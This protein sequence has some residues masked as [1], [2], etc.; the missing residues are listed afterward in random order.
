VV[1]YRLPEPLERG[2]ASSVKREQQCITRWYITCSMLK[3]QQEKFAFFFINWTK[4]IS[5]IY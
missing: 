2:G 3:I 1:G 4:L 5:S